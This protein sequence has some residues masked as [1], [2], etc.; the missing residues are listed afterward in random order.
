MNSVE[1]LKIYDCL[2]SKD[3]A[4]IPLLAI[5]KETQ[6]SIPILRKYLRKFSKSF[7]RV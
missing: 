1:A 4:G 6:I 5:A 3:S 2:S 7:V